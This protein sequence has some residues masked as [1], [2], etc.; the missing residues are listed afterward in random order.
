ML[1]EKNIN[2]LCEAERLLLKALNNV[3]R[4]YLSH[5]YNRLRTFNIQRIESIFSHEL[6]HHL[7][8]LQYEENILRDLRIDFDL[9]KHHYEI[10][11]TNCLNGLEN[12]LFK[13]D[14]SIHK[15]QNSLS[16]Q[17]LI[18]EIKMEGVDIASLLLDFQKLI[19]Y[20]VSQ[21]N[22]ENAVFI[23]TGKKSDLERKLSVFLSVEMRQCL[24]KNKVVVALQKEDNKKSFWNIYNF[25]K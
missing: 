25:I 1:E 6:Y 3:K 4:R 19:Y 18:G 22:F 10:I 11:N 8:L 21:L 15:G 7:R 12:K 14:L 17:L 24:A 2:T 16:K 20:K 5:S 9:P 23:Y 13:P